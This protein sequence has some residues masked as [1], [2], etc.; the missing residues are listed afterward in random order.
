MELGVANLPKICRLIHA[1][2]R[3]KCASVKNPSAVCNVL[4]TCSQQVPEDQIMDQ[5][6]QEGG[7]FKE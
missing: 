5:H 7:A 6:G 2:L 4:L 3:I 1:I